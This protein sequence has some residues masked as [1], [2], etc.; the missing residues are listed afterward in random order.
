M[1]YVL[2]GSPR[3]RLIFAFAGTVGKP[4]LHRDGGFP[5]AAQGLGQSPQT[6]ATMQR[7]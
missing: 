5:K 4:F 6:A 2:F 1:E 3:I 7:E